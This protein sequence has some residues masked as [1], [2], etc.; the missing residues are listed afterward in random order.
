MWQSKTFC[1]CCTHALQHPCP[2]DC[3]IATQHDSPGL[4]VAHILIV[5][6]CAA[7]WGDWTLAEASRV[8]IREALKNPLNQ[9]FIMLSESCVP[10]YPPAVVYQQL[11]WEKKSRINA[12]D[13]DP[14]YYRDN[15]RCVLEMSS[16]DQGTAPECVGP[17][18]VVSR[19]FSCFSDMLH[20]TTLLDVRHLFHQ[21]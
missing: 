12:C 4:S 9:R 5:G 3:I 7:G 6:L 16:N 17:F 20:K 8:L 10:L 14:N 15:Y 13:S 21:R 19:A 1:G 2:Q 18:C 11:M